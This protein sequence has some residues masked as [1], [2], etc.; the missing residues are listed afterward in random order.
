[1]RRIVFLG[2]I[3]FFALANLLSANDKYL[4]YTQTFPWIGPE[5]EDPEV[6]FADL[7][8]QDR[9]ISVLHYESRFWYDCYKWHNDIGKIRNDCLYKIKVS[10]C[11]SNNYKK[12]VVHT[13]PNRDPTTII[14]DING[15]GNYTSIQEGINN[16]VNG[17]TILVY[18]GT[19]FENINYNGKNI[20]VASLYITT[21]TDSFIHKTI[22][23]GNQNG[24]VVT[25]ESGEDTAAVLCGFTIQ[26]GS[27]T[28]QGNFIVGGGI[29][30][31][32]SQS[33]ISNCRIRNN[34]SQFGGGICLYN[35]FINISDVDIFDNHAISW[36][37]GIGF[38]NSFA[39]FDPINRCDIY[40]N[41]SGNGSDLRAFVNTTS[42]S[43]FVDT[44]TVSK[45]TDYYVSPLDQFTIDIKNCKVNIVD[46]D[47]YVSPSGD[48]ANSGFSQTDP[49]KTLSYA[50][51]KISSDSTSCNRIYLSNG[52]YSPFTNGD[53]FPIN[54]KDY[55]SLQGENKDQT[56][57]DGN[58]EYYLLYSYED[59][60]Y[61]IRDITFQ[62]G[63]NDI[64]GG[65]I[66]IH[67]GHN[68]LV[69]NVN[70]LSNRADIGGGGL[71]I[72]ES[73]GI[74]KN[75]TIRNN[76]SN[77]G[78]G[79]RI[80][81]NSN[82]VL[83]NCIIDS[84]YI[85][86]P[87]W[88]TTGGVSC[89]V[90]CSPVFINTRVTNNISDECS[91]MGFGSSNPILINCT[92]C[93]NSDNPDGTINIG[94]NTMIL[95]NNVILR[96][97]SEFE[98][99]YWDTYPPSVAEV[100]YT[101]IKD[102]IN[103]INTNN[104]GTI[105]WGDGN[106][107]E[108]PL[109]VGGDPFSYELT[110]YSPCIDAGTPDTTGLHL[111]ATDLAGNPRIYNGRI[112]IGAYEYQGYGI[113]EPDTSFIHNLYLFKNAPN[114]FKEST[115]ISFISADYERI[116]EYTLSIYNTKGQL[117]RRYNGNEEN[118]WVKTEIVWNGTDEQGKQVAPGTYLYKLEYNGH[119]VVRKMVLLR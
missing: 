66:S 71:N 59:G 14:V 94:D 95:K 119:A 22:I 81:N 7:I 18:P 117:V 103:G 35:T 2:L 48:D 6:V 76:S 107:D 13:P 110:K 68:I 108:D 75:L 116:K 3:I 115:T 30:C 36:A 33:T 54:C 57:L 23:D 26:N 91:G 21:Q 10:C 61:S 63:F 109:F 105:I 101:N 37:G 100:Y 111:P 84:N 102:S 92:I 96:N 17:D 78:G 44:F 55:V 83:I 80:S 47:L 56:I 70:L 39:L 4:T 27:G 104:N 118:F 41:Y 42:V 113:D 89:V 50:M 32:N 5:G 38:Y 16:S 28:E 19:Y 93:D 64:T 112:D 88:G 67:Y 60:D 58:S 99:T 86:T 72:F 12:H 85:L 87:G 15:T 65:G 77:G 8:E 40:L 43:V 51:T 9:L 45:P 90:D 24:S 31:I 79:I 62:N 49:L 73:Q 34:L 20:T 82:P 114:P 25:F 1:M 74:F 69:E 29:F 106:I 97:Y 52:T 53:I 11:V 98:I 46:S